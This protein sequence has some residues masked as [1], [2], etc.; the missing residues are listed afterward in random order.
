MRI[1]AEQFVINARGDGVKLVDALSES[2][3][4]TLKAFLTADLNDADMRT[5][6]SVLAERAADSSSAIEY[7]DV[8]E[9]A[10]SVR[11]IQSLVEADG[12]Q[13]TD[14][15]RVVQETIYN[16]EDDGQILGQMLE[17]RRT[18]HYARE[19]G[20][21]EV[22]PD[23]GGTAEPDIRVGRGGN[24]LYLEEKMVE[25]DLD[26]GLKI[27]DKV[28]EADGSF[29]GIAESHNEVVEISAQGD[30]ASDFNPTTSEAETPRESFKTLIQVDNDPN[31]PEIT[32]LPQSPAGFENPEMTIRVITKDGELVDGGEFTIREVYEEVNNGN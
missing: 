17:A 11:E 16:S 3:P 22:D 7:Q 20:D 6:R 14:P 21:A 27:K 12:T 26:N 13:I 31:K 28:I 29:N 4:D 8:G 19:Y 18:V 24:T 32:G 9:Y 23:I 5:W 30:I 15:N 25:E 2:E 10:R 1:E